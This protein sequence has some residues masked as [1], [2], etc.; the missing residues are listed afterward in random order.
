[1]SLYAN[2]RG[3]IR[4]IPR[5]VK[6]KDVYKEISYCRP[7]MWEHSEYYDGGVKDPIYRC[8]ER[9]PR[10]TYLPPHG[11]DQENSCE[12]GNV[13]SLFLTCKELG[14]RTRILQNGVTTIGMSVV[15]HVGVYPVTTA[16]GQKIRIMN[17]GE[18]AVRKASQDVDYTPY[19][20]GRGAVDRGGFVRDKDKDFHKYIIECKPGEWEDAKHYRGGTKEPIYRFCIRLHEKHQKKAEFRA[21][22]WKYNCMMDPGDDGN[23]HGHKDRDW[24]CFEK[25]P[26][27]VALPPHGPPLSKECTR[28]T[29]TWR[30]LAWYT[31]KAPPEWCPL[32]WYHKRQVCWCMPG[33]YVDSL[34][35][36]TVK[37]RTCPEDKPYFFVP[38][39]V[40][41]EKWTQLR[42]PTTTTTTTTTL[43][44]INSTAP[45]G[46]SQPSGRRLDDIFGFDFD[47][48]V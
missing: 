9:Y 15:K 5:R 21:S 16:M 3:G 14:T 24:L 28:N 40:T 37:Q 32:N 35:D 19:A 13:Q 42:E 45:N 10:Y 48:E 29:T 8:I 41:Y 34:Y 43:S 47:D 6:D 44:P 31:D 23:K 26:E 27:Y 17:R 20:N 33:F 22:P 30:A 7:D 38:R 39:F 18:D 4:F 12:H 36:A 11:I 1:M 2:G 25:R 46:G